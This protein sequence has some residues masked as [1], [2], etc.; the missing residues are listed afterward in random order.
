MIRFGSGE[1]VGRN[2]RKLEEEQAWRMGAA[3]A[4]AGAPWHSCGPLIMNT[5]HRNTRAAGKVPPADV[6]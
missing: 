5:R 3:S 1:H 4:Y 2:D 6:T